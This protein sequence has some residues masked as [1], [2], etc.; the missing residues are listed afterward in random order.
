[1]SIG[2]KSRP[3]AISGERLNNDSTTN[4]VA[5]KRPPPLKI[6]FN[7]H[8][9]KDKRKVLYRN[10]HEISGKI[11][12]VEISRSKLKVFVMLFENFE[13]PT[14]FIIEVLQEKVAHKLL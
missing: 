9:V 3:S 11:F 12:L 10:F 8:G 2:Y 6:G 13:N 1:M 14:N 4:I 5:K 7:E